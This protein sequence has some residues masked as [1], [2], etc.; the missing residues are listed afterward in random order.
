MS[1]PDPLTLPGE[2]PGL[3]R[4]GSPIV[5][6]RGERKGRVGVVADTTLDSIALCAL[7]AT[8]DD[9]ADLRGFALNRAALDL[10]DATG[11][12]H[13]LWW[14]LDAHGVA[15]HHRAS[16]IRGERGWVLW[17]DDDWRVLPP[18]VLGDLNHRDPRLLPDGTRW[19][20]AEA[21]RVAARFVAQVSDG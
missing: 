11:R 6:V 7:E 4:R 20:D 14:L 17:G 10:A 9:D 13:A 18:T 5:I 16:L 12:T 19:V 2:I 1:V 21:I 8:V 3:L 15:R